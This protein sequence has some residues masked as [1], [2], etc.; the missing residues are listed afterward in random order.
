M[1]PR[2]SQP[3]KF[4]HHHI[5]SPYK[6]ALK[7]LTILPAGIMLDRIWKTSYFKDY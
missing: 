2:L 6:F 7:A 4:H 5:L 1:L 3:L